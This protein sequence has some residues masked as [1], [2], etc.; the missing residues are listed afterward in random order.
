MAGRS[1][2]VP[3]QATTLG[4]RFATIADELLVAV[5]RVEELLERLPLRGIKGRS[6]PRRTCST[7]STVT[8]TGSRSWRPRV[9]AHL[10]FTRV[11]TS[12]GQIY[13]RSL[14]HDVVSSL[15]Q[16]VSA[17]SNLATTIRLMAGSSW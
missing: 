10:G 1:H 17:P 2:N 14:D 7:C 3:A 6:A 4:K 12:V 9:A 5:E 15:V 8:P 11:L 16:L 13:P